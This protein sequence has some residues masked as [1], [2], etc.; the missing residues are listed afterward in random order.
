MD[1]TVVFTYIDSTAHRVVLES[2]CLL[3]HDD[4]SFAGRNTRRAMKKIAPSVWQISTSR[5]LTPELYTFR[6]FVD[7]KQQL[8]LN[9]YEVIWKRNLQKYIFLL[10]GDAQSNLYF[11]TSPQGHLDTLSWLNTKGEQMHAVVYLP[12][13]YHDSISYP[14]LYLLH[15]INGNQYDWVGQGRIAQIVDNLICQQRIQELI[16]VMPRCLLST[17]KSDEHVKATNVGNYGEI[18]SGKFED[19]FYAIHSYI[20]SLYKVRDTCNAIA[21]LSCGARQAVNIAHDNSSFFSYVGLFSPVVSRNQVPV[22]SNNMRYWV[23]ACAND[24]MFLGNAKRYVRKLE[25]N[26]IQFQYIE[27]IGGHTFTNWRKFVT[28]F[29]LWAYPIDTIQIIVE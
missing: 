29:L 1:S 19:E 23:G 10:S 7:G 17:P 16:V 18:L 20:Q 9:N 15:G 26:N 2:E 24:W 12:A 22:V 11:S 21:G 13:S 28:E 4:L 27:N 5:K 25:K 14:V 6:L 3:P 8:A